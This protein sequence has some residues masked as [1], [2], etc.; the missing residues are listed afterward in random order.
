MKK[1]V[2]I[3]LLAAASIFQGCKDDDSDKTPSG[4]IYSYFPVNVGHEQIYD[5][6]LITK[7][8]F[9][10]AEDTTYYQI[11]EVVESVF[12]DNQGRP[13]QRLER[14]TRL[15]AND[16]WVIADVW[17]SNLTTTRVEKKEEN[18]PYVKMVFPLGFGAT[19]DGNSLNIL[20]SQTYEITGLNSTEVI[21]GITFDSTLTVLQRDED[22]F[23]GKDYEIE[24]YAT[25]VGL[26]YKQQIHIEKDYTNPNN[27]GVKAQR[28][29]TQTIVSWT[30]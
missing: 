9:S 11:K 4:L 16:P 29:F 13:T 2:W 22:T 30:N 17:T 12:N 3:L 28:L 24:Q 20:E 19:W 15:D 5:A 25:G 18:V 8:D 21:N 1:S 6:V 7:D 23:I 10:G 14:Y 26:V 27:P